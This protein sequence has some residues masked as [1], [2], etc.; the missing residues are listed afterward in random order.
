MELLGFQPPSVIQDVGSRSFQHDRLLAEI[1]VAIPA[2]TN[3][4]WLQHDGLVAVSG[5]GLVEADRAAIQAAINAHDGSLTS[6]ERVPGQLRASV[7]N[8]IPL[9]ESASRDAS[10]WAALSVAERQEVLRLAVKACA[11][12]GRGALREFGE[13][14]PTKA[15]ATLTHT[16]TALTD[17][18]TVTIGTRTYTFKTVLTGA[19]NEVLIG[20][21]T[22]SLA[23][24]KAAVNG[25]AGAGT[26]YGTGTTPH[27]TVDATTL[28]GTTV[29]LF[30]AKTA[31]VAGNAIA[32][33]EGSTNLAWD[34]GATFSGGE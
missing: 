24:L 10:S 22:A 33:G 17:G 13:W 34:V 28:T 32:K 19:P 15:S 11:R 23:N 14:I 7:L 2:V 3:V 25:A 30:E 1:Q 8:V 31:G 5:D 12:I 9:L 26:T 16:G 6:A 20:A 29:L 27:T 18:D 21:A 4:Y